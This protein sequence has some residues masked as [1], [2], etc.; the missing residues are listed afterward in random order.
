[1]SNQEIAAAVNE[2]YNGF[3]IRWKD[4]KNSERDF[5][6]IYQESKKLLEKYKF[7]LAQDMVLALLDELDRR[8]YEQ[9][10]RKR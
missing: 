4:R 2:I 3:W 9:I 5:D 10:N 7:K 1:M 8:T 6:Q